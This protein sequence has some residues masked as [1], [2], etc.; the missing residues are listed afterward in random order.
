MKTIR[1]C[2]KRSSKMISERNSW[3]CFKRSLKRPYKNNSNNIKTIQIKKLEKTQ[4]Q[5]YELREDFNKLKVNRRPETLK[6]VQE[7]AG[8]TLEAIRHRQ[9]LSQ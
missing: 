7:R 9:G 5:L 8:N 2:S 4:K 1:R 6:L 3:R